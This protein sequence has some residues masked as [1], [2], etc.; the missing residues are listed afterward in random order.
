M[1]PKTKP[2]RSDRIKAKLLLTCAKLTKF[3]AKR[4]LESV[5]ALEDVG[6]RL[7]EKVDNFADWVASKLPKE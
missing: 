5:F 6:K 3:G 7:E 4:T 2:S 1:A